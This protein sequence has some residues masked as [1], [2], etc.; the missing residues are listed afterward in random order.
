MPKNLVITYTAGSCGDLISIP[1]V[2][3][4]EFYSL[5]SRHKIT[6]SGRAEAIYDQK[7]IEQFPKQPYLHHYTRNWTEDLISLKNLSNPFLILTTLSTQ[8]TL[9]KDFFNDEVHILSINYNTSNWPFVAKS[10]CSKV[11]DS[12]NYLSRDDVGEKFLNTIAKNKAHREQFLYLS[13][14][15][16]LGTWYAKQLA[17][18][19][20]NYPPK[21]NNFKGDTTLY[22]DEILDYNLLKPKLQFIADEIKTD[23]D[24]DNFNK[25]YTNWYSRQFQITRIDEALR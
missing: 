10:F 1:F 6:E 13:R 24:L 17:L 22:L 11:L 16:L 19:N 7:F 12:Q 23:I 4:G 21:E 2:S 3:S 15:G 14:K 18:D 20:L 25:I 9:I 8:A 5:I